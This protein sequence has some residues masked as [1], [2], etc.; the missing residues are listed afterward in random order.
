MFKIIKAAAAVVLVF[1]IFCACGREKSASHT[2]FLLDTAVSV[3]VYG[4]NA[5]SA[6]AQITEVLR[7]QDSVLSS[8]YDS[9]ADIA[10]ADASD[11]ADKTA[12]LN[13]LYGYDV[14][15][16]CGSLTRLWGISDENPRLPTEGEIAEALRVIPKDKSGIVPGKTF[17]DPGAVGKGYTLDRAKET[18]IGADID[19]AVV[20]TESSVLLFGEKP[21]GEPFYTGIK[22][23]SGGYIGYV[24]TGA[25]FISTAGGAER[26]FEAD[27]KEYIH[28]LDLKNG[29]PAESDLAS[30]TVIIPADETDGGIKSDFLSTLMFIAG[31]ENLDKFGVTYAAV[32]TDGT[33]YTNTEVFTDYDRP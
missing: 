16:F 11:L 18:L 2:E 8:L 15:I 25:A 5:E 21:G 19:Y 23:P 20:S 28:I 27:G 1:L 30:V 3:G 14:N 17:I 29:Y 13:K 6:A 10:I 32:G 7:G 9:P 31:A 4:K 22:N 12:A 24:K 33:V 26:F